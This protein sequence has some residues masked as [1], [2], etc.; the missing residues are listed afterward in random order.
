MAVSYD[1]FAPGV[2]ANPYP[3]Y[4]WLRSTS[5]CHYVE[6]RDF[7]V[8]SRYDDVD[9]VL[10]NHAIFS[11][12]EGVGFGRRPFRDMISADPPEHTRLRR[13]LDRQFLPRAVAQLETR[14]QAII[15]SLLDPILERGRAD[16][17]ADL[18][19]PLPLIVIAEL[20]GVETERRADFKRWSDDVL[21]AAGGGLDE[22]T[23]ARTEESRRAM[24][25]YLR[26]AAAD[27]HAH[28]RPG[29]TDIIST[30]VT[31]SDKDALT[32]GEVIAFCMLLLVAGNETTTNTVANGALAV[33]DHP[34]Q[35]R[36]IM[37]D[38]AL[39]PSFVEES[40]RYDSAI[41][42]FFRTAR[43]DAEIA[44]TRIPAGARVLVL[45]GSANR[46]DRHYRD[47]DTFIG[48]RNPVDHLAFGSGVHFCLGAH[49]ARLELR[50]LMRA[51]LMRVRRL[52]PDGEVVRVHNP[53]AR[54]VHRLPVVVESR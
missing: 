32:T 15:D 26:A 45:F 3:W 37:S 16:L 5:P 29:A 49:L 52:L 12:A 39:V 30:L 27:R 34:D 10:C 25:D 33:M 4:R 18:A 17:V 54:S 51:F 21:A 24:A 46:D 44:A 42:G 11:S 53:I 50:L 19:A 28:P 8:V 47:P 36:P 13:L 43:T 31:A 6:G 14:V 35:W 7:W 20:L 23:R 22:A 9:A 2:L 1:P 41:Q 38:P 40:L 48:T